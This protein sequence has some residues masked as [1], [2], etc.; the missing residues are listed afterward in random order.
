MGLSCIALSTWL[1][2]QWVVA[3]VVPPANAAQTDDALGFRDGF[4]STAG[5]PIDEVVE[6]LRLRVPD[7]RL[8]TEWDRD[9]LTGEDPGQ[10][11]VVARAVDGGGA[12]IEVITGDGRGF[13]R[14]VPAGG[15]D[16]R[17]TSIAI[18]S[19]LLSIERHEAV[20]LREDVAIPATNR[21]DDVEAATA[22][23]A[24]P[25][26]DPEPEPEPEPE[27]KPDP[28][29]LQPEPEPESGLVLPGGIEPLDAASAAE[30]WQLGLTV[31][32][33]VLF[34][35]G[36]PRFGS[37]LQA[38]G[39]ELSVAA[40]TPRG[41]TFG[42]GV[43][44]LARERQE[45][46]LARARVSALAGYVFRLGSFELPA[47]LDVGVEPWLVSDGD[48]RLSSS[49][50]S[51]P[52]SSSVLF[53]ATARV[54]PGWLFRPS[55][56]RVAAV[57]LGADLGLGAGFVVDDGPRVATVRDTSDPESAALFRIGGFEVLAGASATV[58]LSLLPGSLQ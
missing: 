11:L 10:V 12:R 45:R 1:V 53:S 58:W 46:R 7:L 48:G 54:Q 19:L 38:A 22:S 28:V 8:H 23:L 55:P 43:R 51:A 17:E 40:R 42:L 39:A 47:T 31:A 5:L 50:L 4:V 49:Q 20:A 26:A 35:V 37:L 56:D 25:E 14:T 15:D 41:A 16:L 36:A 52:P 21:A 33:G 13:V 57:R 44:Y 29:A 24:E 3:P 2:A 18:A 6:G 9:A 34:G 32:P 27:S 30:P